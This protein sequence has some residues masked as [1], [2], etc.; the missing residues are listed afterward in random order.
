MK[1]TS[2]SSS[3]SENPTIDRLFDTA[4]E[5]FWR[6]GYAA[7]TTREI[8]AAF[9]VQQA[10]LYHHIANKE[11]LLYRICVS[12]LE[13][14]VEQVPSEVAQVGRPSDRIRSLIHAHLTTLLRFQQ[15]N[16]TQLTELRSLSARHRTEVLALRDKYEQFSRSILKDAQAADAIRS[17][18]PAKYLNLELMSIL[19][20]ASLWFRKGKALTE[21]DLA[22]IFTK[23]FLDGAATP[24][25]RA[26]LA[27][28]DLSARQ[29]EGDKKPARA[30]KTATAT[31]KPALTRALDA[32]VG[33][34]S[35]K[36]YTAT[37]TREVA[38]LLGIQKAT[39]YY[40]VESKEDLLFL[41]CQSSLTQIRDDVETA[42]R[43]VPDPLER[44]QT[45]I[46]THIESLLR[47][48]AEHS[49]T[50]TEMHALS[51]ERFGQIMKLRDDYE[52]MVRSVLRE[53][54]DAG[55]VRK[56]IEAKYLSL[57]LLGIMNRV[58]IWYRRGGPLSPHQL[59]RLLG[60]LFLGG[61]RPA[62]ATSQP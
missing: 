41:I 6:Q 17:D 30:R 31:D 15:R 55:V 53:A 62:G 47:D 44:L 49:T 16:V 56:D 3:S 36:G 34:F 23:V 28:P 10:S 7:T 54:Q 21:D 22:D 27:L 18:V 40:H 61:A 45:L 26:R 48:E 5:L 57:I 38:K 19:N 60:A 1:L 52:N 11:D 29:S 20:H 4:A 8:A 2:S 33:L 46:C 58:M 14:F 24:E 13:P 37:S 51:E 59:G 12:S 39:L 9:G 35:R 50:F 43:E 25:L 42:I 32:A